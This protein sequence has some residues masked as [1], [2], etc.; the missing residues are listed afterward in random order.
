MFGPA[1]HAYV[2]FTY[3]MHFC[4]NVV[5][6][7][8]GEGSAVLVRALEPLEGIEIMCHNRGTLDIRNLCSGP[9][10]LCQALKITQALNGHDLSQPPLILKAGQPVSPK[11]VVKTKRIGIS[12]A[13]DK[14]WRFYL[15]DSPFV[16]KL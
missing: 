12:R 10:K 5:T 8:A 6:G 13:L 11:Q 9:A 16:S 7:S 1:G 4:F 3:G 2:Y 14:E 15:K